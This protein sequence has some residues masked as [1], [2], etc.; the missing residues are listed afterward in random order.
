MCVFCFMSLFLRIVIGKID[1]VIDAI[2]TKIF[3][4]Y[5]VPGGTWYRYSNRRTFTY[6]HIVHRM[7]H[8]IMMRADKFVAERPSSQSNLERLTVRTAYV[9]KNSCYVSVDYP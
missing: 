2:H 5:Q 1:S 4:G 7:K 3:T 9:D 8:S 6:R